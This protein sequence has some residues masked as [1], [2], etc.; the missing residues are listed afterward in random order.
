L[1]VVVSS[2]V[3]ERQG[4]AR[5][6]L[7]WRERGALALLGLPSFALSL[8]ITTVGAYLPVLISELAGSL[9]TG[10][11]IG[12]EGVFALFVPL[13]VAR[14]SQKRAGRLGRRLPFLLATAPVIAGALVLMPLTGGL[15]TLAVALLAF[16]AAYFSYLGPYWAL[17]PELVPAGM[18][19]RSQ[20]ALSAWR[21]VGLGVGLVGGGLLLA[22]WRP[23]PFW[24]AGTAV[25]AVTLGLVP[26]LRARERAASGQEEP[27]ERS[28]ADAW[29]LLRDHRRVRR[30]VAANA[31][32][33]LALAALRAFVVLFITVGLGRSASSASALL[34]L[35]A[36][37][38]IVAAL[39]AGPLADRVGHLRLL[40]GAPL[41][42]GL[43]L[44]APAFVHSAWLLAGLPVAAFAAGVV[45]TLPYS[46]LLSVLPEGRQDQAAGVYGISRGFGLLLGPVLAGLAIELLAPVLSETQGYA[47]L[48]LVAAAAVL[49]SLPL[50][51]ALRS[52]KVSG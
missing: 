48:W 1:G 39:V 21:E 29:R 2:S 40:Q 41:L 47:A 8:A 12:C 13:L 50:L 30:V 44:L 4:E 28:L 7:S 51:V 5:G 6:A 18:R 15:V 17:F 22:L 16:Y 38:V 23:A 36:P 9:V 27:E 11:L 14:R 26:F 52:H 34:A 31:L 45:M 46:L 43:G 32:W 35:V 19:G 24:L 3:A 20:S 10:L 33:E 49:G 37:P 42:Y 25:L